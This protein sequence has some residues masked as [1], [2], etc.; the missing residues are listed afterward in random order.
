MTDIYAGKPLTRLAQIP[1]YILT[2]AATDGA[3]WSWE[4][5]DHYMV[6]QVLLVRHYVSTGLEGRGLFIA[7]TVLSCCESTAWNVFPR[8][9]LVLIN[10]KLVIAMPTTYYLAVHGDDIVIDASLTDALGGYA[11]HNSSPNAQF[12]TVRIHG[13]TLDIVAIESRRTIRSSSK[14]LMSYG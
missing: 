7:E 13:T 5:I 10:S 3:H 4:L 14:V 6:I 1:S 8:R 2:E 9:L 12:V 11:K